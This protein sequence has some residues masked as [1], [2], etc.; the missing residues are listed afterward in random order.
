M[1]RFGTTR[2][3]D[4]LPLALRIKG[5]HIYDGNQNL[6]NS[7][8]FQ[9]NYRASAYLRTSIMKDRE[10]KTQD[11]SFKNYK[12]DGS[13]NPN[14]APIFS[15]KTGVREGQVIGK[16]VFYKEIILDFYVYKNITGYAKPTE[17][18]PPYYIHYA[19]VYSK[20]GFQGIPGQEGYNPL[21]FGE[22]FND[23]NNSTQKS[24]YGPFSF[25][26]LKN[27]DL[28]TVLLE[29]D[30]IMGTY[31]PYPQDVPVGSVLLPPLNS[32]PFSQH[33]RDFINL[34]DLNYN[35]SNPN[36]S[37]FDS[38]SPNPIF[39]QGLPANFQVSP[40]SSNIVFNEISTGSIWLLYSISPEEGGD[41]QELVPPTIEFYTRTV[42]TD[43]G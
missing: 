31:N 8:L 20:K 42:Y 18:V 5:A 33:Y 2:A 17:D 25:K 11:Y 28:F 35:H 19:L 21:S 37:S 16:S 30:L 9:M 3:R 22:V 32:P 7:I 26:S 13:M 12:P 43:E 38:S 10:V 15:N 27:S 6:Q 39:S 29:R 34:W 4:L 41:G 14:V 24:V 1:S 40:E 36:S 23:I